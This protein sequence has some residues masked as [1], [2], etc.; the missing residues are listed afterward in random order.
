MMMWWCA[1]PRDEWAERVAQEAE[2]MRREKNPKTTYVNP[3]QFSDPPRKKAMSYADEC[4]RDEEA[5]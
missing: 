1:V 3:H 5:L 4:R 2:R